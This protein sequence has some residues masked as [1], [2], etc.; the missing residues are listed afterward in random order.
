MICRASALTEL[1]P[2]A[3]DTIADMTV[4]GRI[5]SPDNVFH[6]YPL[7]SEDENAWQKCR[8]PQQKAV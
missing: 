2:V 5:D 4:T 6:L 7:L 8:R 1:T 3:S